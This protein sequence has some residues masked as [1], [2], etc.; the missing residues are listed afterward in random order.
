MEKIGKVK[1][2]MDRE[3]TVLIESEV[4]MKGEKDRDDLYFI[5]F[6][7]MA[8]PLRLSIIT[9]GDLMTLAIAN[10]EKE[11]AELISLLEADPEQY[12]FLALG[13]T[14]LLMSQSV[15]KIKIPLDSQSNA[16]K[17]R[18]IISS[19]IDKCKFIQKSNYIVEGESIYKEQEVDTTNMIPQLGMMLDIIKKWD[20]ID[21]D[22]LENL[23]GGE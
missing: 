8:D 20:E 6:N 17:A 5:M 3:M 22:E 19:M 23:L 1:L 15:E 7:I 10:T 21:L 11:E 12:V 13:N 14:E 18:I 4:T 2:G 16:D 9:I